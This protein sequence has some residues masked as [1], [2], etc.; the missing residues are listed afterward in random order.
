MN[1]HNIAL[2]NDGTIW[3]WGKYID[4]KGM[5]DNSGL[6][7]SNTFGEPTPALIKGID[8]VVDVSAGFNFDIALKDDGSVWGWG[9]NDNGALGNGKNNVEVSPIPL[10]SA[11]KQETP[12][13]SATSTA[14]QA[15]SSTPAN[16]PKATSAPT[17]SQ[18]TPIPTPG[19]TF[20]AI[21]ALGCIL[22]VTGLFGHG[23]RKND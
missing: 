14:T 3:T 16:S 12:T 7:P 1:W 6:P 20:S 11:Q 19:F 18:S 10:F 5:N 4:A 23:R 17:Q 8:H 13:P 21:A 2:K 22:I 9:R 15:S